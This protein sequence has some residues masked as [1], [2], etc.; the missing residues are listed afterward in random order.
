VDAAA[1]VVALSGTLGYFASGADAMVAAEFGGVGLEAVA[2]DGVVVNTAPGC[3][4]FARFIDEGG[5]AAIVAAWGADCVEGNTGAVF[6]AADAVADTRGAADRATSDESSDALS[7]FHQAQR[8]PDWQPA[9]PTTIANI[10]AVRIAKSFIFVLP[11]PDRAE[12][13]SIPTR[14]TRSS[15]RHHE[16]PGSALR[17][18]AEADFPAWGSLYDSSACPADGVDR[19]I[20]ACPLWHFLD[21]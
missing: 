9:T 16:P 19:F 8:G 11:S 5:A 2:T 14:G 13:K 10:I 12:Q 1:G 4:A 7:C 21:K 20:T 17:R 15:P 6:G 3:A 18:A